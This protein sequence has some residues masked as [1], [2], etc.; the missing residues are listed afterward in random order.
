MVL[1]GTT[2]I[3]ADPFLDEPNSY[4]EIGIG[5]V[6]FPDGVSRINWLWLF[7]YNR[8]KFAKNGAVG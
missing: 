4:R 1:L 5:V 2:T 3:A 6:G 7:E 8:P